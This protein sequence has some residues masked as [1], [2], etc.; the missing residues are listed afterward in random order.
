M[1][2]KCSDKLRKIQHLAALEK[3]I[4]ATFVVNHQNTGTFVETQR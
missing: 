1:Q 2:K 3:Y 4:Y